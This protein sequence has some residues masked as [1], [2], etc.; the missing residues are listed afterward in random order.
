LL[1]FAPAGANKG[2]LAFLDIVLPA[3]ALDAAGGIYQLLFAGKEGVAG[4]AYFHFDIL[5]GGT[6]FDDVTAGAAYLG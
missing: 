1:Q 5:D 3:E 6:R 4:R 2:F